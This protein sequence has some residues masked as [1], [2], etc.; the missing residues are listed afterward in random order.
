VRAP[1]GIYPLSLL[2]AALCH[3]SVANAAPPQPPAST[4]PAEDGAWTMP[5]K[6]AA[7]TRFSGF[8]QITDARG[9]GTGVKSACAPAFAGVRL[10]ILNNIRGY[11]VYRLSCG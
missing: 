10:G 8:D 5:G 9:G 1:V 3:I 2:I 4:A 6:N 7:S 11:M